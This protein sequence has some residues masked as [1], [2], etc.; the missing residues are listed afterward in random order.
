[1]SKKRKEYR[2]RGGVYSISDP[3]GDMYIGA[4]VDFTQRWHVHR[5]ELRKGIHHSPALQAAWDQ[6]GEENILF[7]ELEEC[8]P[9]DLPRIEQAYFDRLRP[10]FN[11]QVSARSWAGMPCNEETK[12]KISATTKGKKFS[13][14]TRA[15]ISAALKGRKMTDEHKRNL[16]ESRKRMFATRKQGVE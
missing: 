12:R 5:Y 7:R 1:M 14:E 11:V 16:S 13:D 8:G 9:D 4:T 2:P 6:Y 10:K 3:S 15:R